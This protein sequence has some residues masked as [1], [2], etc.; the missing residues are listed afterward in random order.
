MHGAGSS[1]Q[2]A[3]RQLWPGARGGK[4]S[5]AQGKGSGKGSGGKDSAG[6]LSAAA[7]FAKFQGTGCNSGNAMPKAEQGVSQFWACRGPGACGFDRNPRGLGCTKCVSC[8]LPW[9]YGAR[10][11]F[12]DDFLARTRGKGPSG[13]GGGA[14][15]RGGVAPAGKGACG[16]PSATA[17]KAAAGRAANFDPIEDFEEAQASRKKRR[18]A[19]RASGVAARASFAFCSCQRLARSVAI[20]AQVSAAIQLKGGVFAGGAGPSLVAPSG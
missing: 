15:S 12:W 1:R 16:G 4:L 10:A 9:A 6:W 3:L 17:A 20:L 14:V 11:A 19:S 2:A 5:G 7:A 13:S 8:G 18:A